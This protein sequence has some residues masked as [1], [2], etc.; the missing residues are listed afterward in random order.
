MP[1]RPPPSLPA[2][3][4]WFRALIVGASSGMGAALARQLGTAGVRLALVARRGE[5][6]DGLA[7]EIVHEGGAARPHTYVHDVQDIDTVPALL[8]GICRD[9]EGL[10]LFIYAAGIMPRIEQ[11]QYDSGIDQEILGVNLLGAVA[12]TNAVVPRFARARSG[13]I[14][15]LS[16]VAGDRGRRAYPAYAA[17]KAGHTTY[18]ES[19]RNRVGRL[20]VRVVTVKPGPVDTPMTAGLDRVP[21]LIS[22]DQ[23]ARTILSAAAR[24]RST[25]YIP[26]RW[27]PIMLAIRMIPSRLFRYLDI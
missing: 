13:T 9:L 4:P 20:G 22:A 17:A 3:L 21:F 23:A 14:V 11:E 12:W 18:L 6:L 24:G 2:S 26:W 27:R 8:E 7:D 1:E 16:S 5:L 15:G 25:V 10:D 19:I